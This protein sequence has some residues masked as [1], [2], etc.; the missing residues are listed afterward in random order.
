MRYFKLSFRLVVFLILA[1]SLLL[2]GFN[3]TEKVK[4]VDYLF[5]YYID[6]GY[7]ETFAKNIVTAIYLKYRVFDTLFETLLLFIAATAVVHN[8]NKDELNEEANNR[9]R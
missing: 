1:T 7:Q 8:L 3:T 2:L 9:S 6:N 4:S 5:H